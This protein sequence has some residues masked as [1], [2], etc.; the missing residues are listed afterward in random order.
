MQRITR[1]IGK[2]FSQLKAAVAA[3]HRRHHNLSSTNVIAAHRRR[4]CVAEVHRRVAALV[5]QAAL[6]DICHSL[7]IVIRH[8]QK[9]IHP[10]RHRMEYPRRRNGRESVCVRCAMNI[11]NASDSGGGSC[12]TCWAGTSA[13]ARPPASWWARTA[14]CGRRASWRPWARTIW[15]CGRGF[16]HRLR[17]VRPEIHRISRQSPA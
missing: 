15:C 4:R 8:I 16:L 6:L 11:H 17:P 13:A 10:P 7:L 12:G 3:G 9:R 14:W 1:R 5:H 2:I